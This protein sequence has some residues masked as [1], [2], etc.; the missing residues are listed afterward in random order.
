MANRLAAFQKHYKWV[1]PWG[2]DYFRSRVTQAKVDSKE[3]LE[4]TLAHCNTRALQEEAVQAL[5]FKCDLL[6]AMLD[7]IEAGCKS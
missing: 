7:A 5:Q 2:F 4:L 3:G 6:W 1:K